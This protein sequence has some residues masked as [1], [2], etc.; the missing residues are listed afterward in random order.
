[1]SSTEVMTLG[2][3]ARQRDRLR[4]QQ[5]ERQQGEH[6][7]LSAMD[8]GQQRGQLLVEGMPHLEAGS[9]GDGLPGGGTT[10]RGNVRGREGGG[11]SRWAGHRSYRCPSS[12]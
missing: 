12:C 6:M 10:E 5:T 8:V 1:M 3:D 7:H 9:H 4:P 2:R 11:C